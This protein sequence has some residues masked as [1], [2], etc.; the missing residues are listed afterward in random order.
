MIYLSFLLFFVSFLL[1]LYR[2][3]IKRTKTKLAK[4]LFYFSIFLIFLSVLVGLL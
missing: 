4:R 3:K 1:S 2:E